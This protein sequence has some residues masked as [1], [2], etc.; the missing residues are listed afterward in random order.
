MSVIVRRDLDNDAERSR[1]FGRPG[2]ERDEPGDSLM[3]RRS[4]PADVR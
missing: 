2:E 3:N 1:T 4:Q